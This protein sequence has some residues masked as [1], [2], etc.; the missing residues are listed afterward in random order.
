MDEKDV[1][2]PSLPSDC[3][4]VQCVHPYVAQ[5]PDELTLELADI[6]NIL[7]KT[8]DGKAGAGLVSHSRAQDSAPPGTSLRMRWGG[9]A[10]GGE[11][12][13]WLGEPRTWH[14]SAPLDRS[15]HPGFPSFSSAQRRCFSQGLCSPPHNP[16]GPPL[17]PSHQAQPEHLF[18]AFP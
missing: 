8:E 6:L 7:E 2:P 3:P 16:R 4:Q 10:P 1:P 18:C 14:V 13:R 17:R 9:S 11:A 5:Q 15:A 12:G